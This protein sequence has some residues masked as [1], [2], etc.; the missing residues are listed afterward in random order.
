MDVAQKNC[1]MGKLMKLFEK[2]GLF[3]DIRNI[4][5]IIKLERLQKWV[6]K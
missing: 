6:N 1:E 2:A 5:E 4:N 3:E